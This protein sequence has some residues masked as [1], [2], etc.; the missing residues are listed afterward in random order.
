MSNSVLVSRDAHMP[1]KYYN[2]DKLTVNPPIISNKAP[3]LS[4]AS[5]TL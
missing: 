5:D 3:S 1:T 2:R 4:A